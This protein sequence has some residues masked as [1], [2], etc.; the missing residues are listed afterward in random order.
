[1]L[2]TRIGGEVYSNEMTLSDHED[3]VDLLLHIKGKAMLSGMN[4]MFIN[5]W[6]KLVG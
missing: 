3:L 5:H 6:S 4:T 1:V 2:E